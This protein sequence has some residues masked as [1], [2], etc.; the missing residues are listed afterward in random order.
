MD[1]SRSKPTPFWKTTPLVEE[2]DIFSELAERKGSTLFLGQY[3]LTEAQAVLGKKNFFKESRKRNLWP[4][5][6]DLDSSEYPL[7]RL[8]IY[9]QEKKPARVIVDLKIRKGRF[10]PKDKKVL[11]FSFSEYRCLILEWLT[12]QNPLLT[13]SPQRPRLPGQLYPGLGLGKKVVDIFGYLA[14]LSRLDAILAFPAYFH[15][16]VLFSRFFH[17]LNPVKE[18]EVLA[19]RKAFSDIPFK[20]LAWVVHLNCLKMENGKTYEWKSEEQ[21]IAVHRSLRDYFDSR[22]YRE[23]MKQALRAHS[24]SIDWESFSHKMKTAEESKS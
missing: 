6:F 21:V 20:Q 5:E 14:R 11:G 12:L 10:W 18:A 15:N 13:F 16:A 22:A 23:A 8:R 3:T 2:K 7:Q 1:K 9:Y 4:L 19:I 24:F 17:F